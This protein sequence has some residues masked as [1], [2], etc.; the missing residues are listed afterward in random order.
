MLSKEEIKKIL[1]NGD[2]KILKSLGQNFLIDEN[3]LGKI[4]QTAELNKD[5]VVIEIGPGFGTLTE[6]LSEK[7]GKVIAIEKDKKLAELLERKLSGYSHP[8]PLPERE[9]VVKLSDKGNW[10]GI[11]KIPNTKYQIPNTVVINDDILRV[12]LEEFINKYSFGGKYKLVSN[13]PYYIT[14]PIIKLF[15]ESDIQPELIVLLM[16]KEVAE[17]IC[18][19]PG[20]LSVLALSVQVYGEPEIVDYVDKSSFYPEPKVDSA[21]LKIKNIK[22]NFSDEHYKNLFRIIKIGFSSKRKKLANNLSA[23]LHIGKTQSE[24]L[25]EK[26]GISLNARAQELGLEDWRK[27]MILLREYEI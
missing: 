9:G 25:L 2:L 13:I 11:V 12:D 15:L 1:K 5:D 4:V 18:A 6:E 24:E 21:I 10:S 8:S 23:G 7:C 19:E 20:K 17:R 16:Q 14:S 26:A 22:K 3:V 27:L